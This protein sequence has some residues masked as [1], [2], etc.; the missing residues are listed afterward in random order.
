MAL[1]IIQDT[2]GIE[3]QAHQAE[4]PEDQVEPDI[5]PEQDQGQNREAHKVAG[6]G[7]DARGHHQGKVTRGHL[8]QPHPDSVP[9]II[10]SV[11]FR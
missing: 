1:Q 5:H 9:W 4:A 11:L 8:V 10:H 6:Q 2:A 7:D 3:D